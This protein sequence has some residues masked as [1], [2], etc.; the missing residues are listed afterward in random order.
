MGQEAIV[1]D[2]RPD[3]VLFNAQVLTVDVAGTAAQALAVKGNRVAAVGSSLHNPPLGGPNKGRLAVGGRTVVPGFID[4]H[5]HLDREGLRRAY[6]DLQACRSIADVQEVVRRAAAGTPPGEWIVLLPPGQPP[7][8]MAPEQSLAERRFPNRHELD[9]AA[10]DNPV[11]IRSIWGLWNNTPPF[12]HVLNSAGIRACGITRH[13]P[14]PRR[15]S[16]SSGTRRRGT[17]PAA[18]WSG[19][20]GRRPSSPF[21][22][23]RHALPTRCD[24]AL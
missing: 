18:F 13:T 2:A 12:V 7:Y 3:T 16:R 4:T 6:P 23:P 20:C 19:I 5:A 9:A 10:P 22:A 24:Y 15:R 21:S 17:S 1:T 8:H 11:W 14:P